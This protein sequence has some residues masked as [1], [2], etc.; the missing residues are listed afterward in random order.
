MDTRRSFRWYDFGL[1]IERFE[2]FQRRFAGRVETG[3]WSFSD[4]AMGGIVG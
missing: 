2:T 1:K 3:Q 4:P